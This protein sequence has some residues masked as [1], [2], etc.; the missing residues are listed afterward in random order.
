M[1]TPT[2]Q[3]VISNWGKSCAI[4]IPAS[5]ARTAGISIGQSMRFEAGEGG[6]I[7]MSPIPQKVSLD[8]LLARVTDQNL[9]DER[10][11]DWGKPVGTEIW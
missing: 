10:D 9:P 4:H 8:S 5:F 11:T 7:I 6:S 3:A 1:T 2:S